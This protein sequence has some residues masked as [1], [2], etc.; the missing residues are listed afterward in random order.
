MVYDFLLSFVFQ[1]AVVARSFVHCYFV[2]QLSCGREHRKILF[3]LGVV[4][5][6]ALCVNM[7]YSSET[8]V[9]LLFLRAWTIM[10]FVHA[11]M[12][13]HKVS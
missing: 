4:V 7:L 11:Y 6:R 12:G 3:L 10:A 5:L 13:G 8:C 1:N 2:F 9:I